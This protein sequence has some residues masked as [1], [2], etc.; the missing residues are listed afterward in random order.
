M[1]KMSYTATTDD[2]GAV[3]LMMEDFEFPS[4]ITS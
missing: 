1:N 3:S 4:D 2:F